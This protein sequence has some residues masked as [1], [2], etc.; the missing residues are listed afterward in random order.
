ML[1]VDAAGGGSGA[2]GSLHVQQPTLRLSIRS[3]TGSEAL[4]EFER[5]ERSSVQADM[6]ALERD[7]A[8]M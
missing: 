5:R 7:A 3:D 2:S 8:G 4:S 1:S 6:S